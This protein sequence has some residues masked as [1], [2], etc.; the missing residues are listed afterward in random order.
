MSRGVT[1]TRGSATWRGITEPA[2]R[3]RFREMFSRENL[4]SCYAMQRTQL[5]A[6]YH[7]PVDS[8]EIHSIKVFVSTLKN[9]ESGDIEAILYSVDTD[10]KEKE[11]KIISAITN[12]E[13]EF[14]ALINS[15]TAKIHYQYAAVSGTDNLAPI[16][17]GDYNEVMRETLYSSF[18]PAEA[19]KHFTELTFQKV[20]E[21]LEKRE[22]YSY[23][24]S[25]VEPYLGVLEK[26]LTF[27]YLDRSNKREILFFRSDITGEIKQER[28]M[29]ELR[30][31]IM[32]SQIQPHF[33]YNTLAVL[34]DMCHGKAPEAEQTTIEF[35]EF[36]RGNL[37]S[38]SQSEPIPFEQ[39]LRHTKNYLTLE[40]KR[41][42]DLLKV[43]YDIR[44]TAFSLPA[45]TL[46][47]IVE[48]A[49]R[50][51]V[52]QRED[53]GTVRITAEEKDNTFVVTVVD[54]GV[55]YDVMVP[56]A[57]G[58]THIGI[59]NVRS[60]LETMSHG[61]LKISSVPGKGTTAVITIP[62][63]EQ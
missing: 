2:D 28:E 59:T 5:S 23:V 29:S 35:A 56:K 44:A 61:T 12:R 7:R 51:G 19:E 63:E 30:K 17:M 9:P 47:P 3:S 58:R 40:T 16:W 1:V 62:K 11:E 32:L 37:D 42:G 52:M 22:E 49:V 50:Y 55:G 33:L 6:E 60:R 14:I 18:N 25:F 46:Q 53:G 31:K 38:L 41:F 20:T 26:R 34:Q 36:L 15:R 13:Y 21:A 10:L 57:D 4:L 45:L 43:D 24:L 48:N 27:L 8:G 39:E 54:D